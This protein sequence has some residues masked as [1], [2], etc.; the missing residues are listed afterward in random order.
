MAD[1][2]NKVILTGENEVIE[3]LSD[4]EIAFIEKIKQ[5]TAAKKAAIAAAEASKETAIA[6]LAALGLDLDDLK[7]LG[8]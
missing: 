5:E 2:L 1:T 6:K 3:P 8:F 4:D 7:A